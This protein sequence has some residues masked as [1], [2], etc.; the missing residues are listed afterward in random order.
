MV[1]DD[2]RQHKD[3]DEVGC[4]PCELS[5]VADEAAGDGSVYLLQTE[6]IHALVFHFVV[7]LDLPGE[8]IVEAKEGYELVPPVL[9]LHSQHDVVLGVC[10]SKHVV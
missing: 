10:S 4:P 7:E 9:P 5:Q 8:L 1:D 2:E 6:D 3:A